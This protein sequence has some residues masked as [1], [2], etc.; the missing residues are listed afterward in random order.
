MN[1]TV[2]KNELIRTLE[3]IIETQQDESGE[4]FAVTFADDMI[5]DIARMPIDILKIELTDEEA[6]FL[7]EYV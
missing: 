2:D 7:R 3:S 5:L 6:T 1:F 4:S